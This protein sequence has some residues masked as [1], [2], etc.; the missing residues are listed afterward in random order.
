MQRIAS[1][2][3]L[4][5][6]VHLEDA[7]AGTSIEVWGPEKLRVGVFYMGSRVS[8][9]SF[10]PSHLEWY[11][12]PVPP[13]EPPLMAQTWVVCACRS[14]V[15]YLC[16]GDFDVGICSVNY[17]CLYWSSTPRSYNGYLQLTD[18]GGMREASEAAKCLAFCQASDNRRRRESPETERCL[19][20][21]LS[22]WSWENEGSAWSH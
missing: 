3:D 18:R 5:G 12:F 1:R 21:L 11:K 16:H 22:F 10:F 7:Q 14:G 4:L 19:I 2:S 15:I 13:S 6:R 20:F 17:F 9:F 8:L